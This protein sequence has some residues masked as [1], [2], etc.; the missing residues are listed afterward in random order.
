[1]T[2]PDAKSPWEAVNKAHKLHKG[3]SFGEFN[4]INNNYEQFTSFGRIGIQASK[5]T[6]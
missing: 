6:A 3:N 1:M 2:T 4:L 5:Q